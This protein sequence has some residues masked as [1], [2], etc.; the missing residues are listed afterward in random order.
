MTNPPPI[1][2]HGVIGMIQE[3]LHCRNHVPLNLKSLKKW[4]P[5]QVAPMFLSANGERPPKCCAS[6]IN[7]MLSTLQSYTSNKFHLFQYT[8]HC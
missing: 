4:L 6:C 7:A 3:N 2:D 8:H 5:R 1:Q